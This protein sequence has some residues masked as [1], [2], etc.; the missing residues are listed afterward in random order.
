MTSPA[1]VPCR[2]PI[3]RTPLEFL[4]RA[5]ENSLVRENVR[6]LGALMAALFKQL[7]LR[8]W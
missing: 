4:K 7:R 8:H 3:E 6:R 5:W 1:R 2:L